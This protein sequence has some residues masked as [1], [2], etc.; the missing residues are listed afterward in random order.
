MKSNL[1]AP[2]ILDASLTSEN[3]QIH[4]IPL[5]LLLLLSLTLFMHEFPV[6]IS[7]L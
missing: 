7:I 1:S 4:E 5:T 2:L 3:A 6:L